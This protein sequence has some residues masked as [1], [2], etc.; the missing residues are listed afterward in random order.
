MKHGREA[1]AAD[2]HVAGI[3]AA[4]VV[5]AAEIKAVVVAVKAKAAGEAATGIRPRITATPCG[6]RAN[7]AGKQLRSNNSRQT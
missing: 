7:R 4:V 6:S 5:T 1:K 3:A 2:L